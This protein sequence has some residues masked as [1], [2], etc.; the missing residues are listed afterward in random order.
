MPTCAACGYSTGRPL[1][2]TTPKSPAAAHSTEPDP[3]VRSIAATASFPLHPIVVDPPTAPHCTK[4]GSTSFTMMKK[5]YGAG[6]G[7]AGCCACGIPGALC[8]AVGAN[9][10][11]RVCNN[12]GN[13]AQLQ[14]H[15]P[16]SRFERVLPYVWHCHGLPERCFSWHGRKMPVCSRCVGVWGG[17]AIGTAAAAAAL[18]T[19]SISLI[20]ML[21]LFGAAGML[22]CIADWSLQTWGGLPSNNLR[23][24]GTGLWGGFGM[25]TLALGAVMSL[26]AL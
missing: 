15:G 3:S 20:A 23:R 6:K 7:I 19:G 17:Q 25:P 8:G 24:L 12:C 4:C 13:Q 21:A 11:I 5:G 26:A 2:G 14:A 10:P 1:P 22:A 9:R 18:L 16:S